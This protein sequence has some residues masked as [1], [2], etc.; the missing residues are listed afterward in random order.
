MGFSKRT[1]AQG[2]PW[3]DGA[4]GEDADGEGADSEDADSEGA[5]SDDADGEG[6]DSEDAD[7]EVLT[8][9]PLTALAL[10]GTSLTPGPHWIRCTTKGVHTA[11][12]TKAS[13]LYTL[14]ELRF[15]CPHRKDV[16]SHREGP[17]TP[18]GKLH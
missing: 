3:G 14:S 6:A 10:S 18:S 17:Y 15:S 2:C 9:T 13:A 16:R 1:P 5:D 7:G 11:S 8:A 4:D 12:Q